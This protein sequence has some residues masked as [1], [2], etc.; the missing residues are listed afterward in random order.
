[1]DL[2]NATISLERDLAMIEPEP[3]ISSPPLS[4][5]S[6][7]VPGLEFVNGVL[8]GLWVE[9]PHRS[10]KNKKETKCLLEVLQGVTISKHSKDY[11]LEVAIILYGEFYK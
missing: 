10:A 2:L 8:L 4:L 1:M 5:Q 9:D 11:W 7:R 6:T 3:H